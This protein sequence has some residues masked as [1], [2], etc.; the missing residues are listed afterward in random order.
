MQGGE[1]AGGED[2]QVSNHLGWKWG[3]GEVISG[4]AKEF[5]QSLWPYQ[6]RRRSSLEESGVFGQVRPSQ[7]GAEA[8]GQVLA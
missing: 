2:D 4:E 7:S 8:D 1:G 5:I 3:S 6:F